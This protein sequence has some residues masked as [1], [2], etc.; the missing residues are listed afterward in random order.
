MPSSGFLA[1]L[2]LPEPLMSDSPVALVTGA[3]SG[4][5]EATARLLVARGWRVAA[6]GRRRDRLEAL[7]ASAPAGAILPFPADLTDE[8]SVTSLLAAVTTAF[9]PLTGLVNAAGILEGG[10]LENASMDSFDRVMNINVRSVALVTKAALPAL[11]KRGAGA[12]I[13]NVSSV[14]GTRSFPGIFAY[15]TSKAALDQMTR[16]LALE[17]AADGIRVN[18]VNPGVVVTELHRASGMEE[19]AYAAFLE[20]SKLTHPMGRVGQPDEVA[21]AIVWLLTDNSGWVTGATLPIDG[22]RHLTCAR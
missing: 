7:A 20:R 11:R 6:T 5:G 2:S 12:A 22:G 8:T 15:C 21:E 1:T 17:L 16:C 18:A 9:G 10:S 3:T 14:T 13:V 19:A 4:I